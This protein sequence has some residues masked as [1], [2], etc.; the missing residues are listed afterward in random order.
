MPSH[1]P[2][3]ICTGVFFAAAETV[4]PAV[5]A[6]LEAVAVTKRSMLAGFSLAF[7]G[8]GLGVGGF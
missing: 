7:E 2:L 3:A 4:G 8:Y 1:W 5:V 6:M